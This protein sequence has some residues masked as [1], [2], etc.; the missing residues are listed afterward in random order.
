MS[1]P[2]LLM[3][4]LACSAAYEQDGEV[5]VLHDADFPRVVQ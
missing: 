4:L 3:V 1:I 2:V 5:L